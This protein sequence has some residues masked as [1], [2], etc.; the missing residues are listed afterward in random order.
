MTESTLADLV[1]D[2]DAAL[3]ESYARGYWPRQ[4]NLT[5]I[6]RRYSGRDSMLSIVTS[7]SRDEYLM[8]SCVKRS[9]IHPL[10]FDKIVLLAAP[11]YQVHLHVWWNHAST[12][13]DIHNH[14]F[15][16]ASGV[17]T[18]AIRMSSYRL[19]G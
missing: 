12:R 4:Q 16:F 8:D 11:N 14:R 3:E 18:G 15:S 7:I 17:V 10:G 9:Q 6:I 19:G 13:E 1:R 2:L 5:S